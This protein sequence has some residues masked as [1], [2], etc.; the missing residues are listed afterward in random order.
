V[1]PFVASTDP[2]LFQI[3]PFSVFQT[4]PS[5]PETDLERVT[6]GEV[7]C[8]DGA[9]FVLNL[10]KTLP[11]KHLSSFILLFEIGFHSVVQAASAS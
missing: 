1:M 11:P 10:G 6:D 8:L 4:L 3:F 9:V 7:L 5:S 2:F